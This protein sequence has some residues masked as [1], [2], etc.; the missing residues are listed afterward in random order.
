MDFGRAFGYIFED[1]EWTPKVLLLAIVSMI[2][3]LNLAITGWTIDLIDGMLDGYDLPLPG[4]DNLG[5]KFAA[6]LNT[7]IAGVIYN[8]P[9]IILACVMGVLGGLF[10]DV[11]GMEPLMALSTCGMT[12][13]IFA[14]A[15]VANGVLFIGVI[16][17][18]RVRRLDAFLQFGQNA[19]IARE[20]TGTLL[21]LAAWL[22]LAGIV[23]S[24]FAWIPCIGWLAAIVIGIPVASHLQG[25][26]AAQIVGKRK[27]AMD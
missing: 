13:V 6:G 18:S 25:Q 10:A 21:A 22:I 12:L 17:Y 16:R 11:Q 1:Q 24:M 20:N 4:W 7:A 26:A 8:L 2:P 9:L 3:I 15:I 19:A 23:I 14:Y 27:R 5:E